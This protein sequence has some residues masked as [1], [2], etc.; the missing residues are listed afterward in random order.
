[1]S[2]VERTGWRTYQFPSPSHTHP[3]PHAHAHPHL[4]RPFSLIAQRAALEQRL[5]L[6]TGSAAAGR[7]WISL[8]PETSPGQG[9]GVKGWGRGRVSRSL[10]HTLSDS[11]CC[12]CCCSTLTKFT[13]HAQRAIRHFPIC[14]GLAK[15][16]V[17]AR[18]IAREWQSE[19]E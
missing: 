12:C 4:P 13:F 16:L 6:S 3:H 1:M 11:C 10:M 5:R 17:S 8:R 19:S 9:S 18:G 7:T 15:H 2:H 14:R